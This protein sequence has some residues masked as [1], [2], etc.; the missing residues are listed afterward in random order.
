MD[1]AAPDRRNLPVVSARGSLLLA[2]LGL[3]CLGAGLF[4]GAVLLIPAG[5]LGLLG[6][7]A[8][9]I[10]H[11]RIARGTAYLQEGKITL[12]AATFV[13]ASL[14]IFVAVAGYI[15]LRFGS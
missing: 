14:S 1:Q 3:V 2:A 12:L 5:T 13:N 7:I 6:L 15:V 10:R 11:V 9:V 8:G 4:A